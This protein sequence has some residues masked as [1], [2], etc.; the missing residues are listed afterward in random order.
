[1]GQ[2]FDDAVEASIKK[3]KEKYKDNKIV[4][5]SQKKGNTKNLPTIFGI[6]P[7]FALSLAK[8]LPTK[9]KLLIWYAILSVLF[10]TGYLGYTLYKLIFSLDSKILLASSG[11]IMIIF[12]IIFRAKSF[13][14]RDKINSKY[15]KR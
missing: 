9:I 6:S 10:S 11:I 12:I 2:N 3:S 5:K 1:M 13:Y 14:K 7:E 4:D 8:Q 15:Q